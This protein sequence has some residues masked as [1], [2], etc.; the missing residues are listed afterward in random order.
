[1]SAPPRWSQ[2]VYA[3]AILAVVIAGIAYTNHV[4]RESE[5]KWCG[6]LIILTGGPPPVTDRGRAVA[7]AM[8][9]LRRDFGC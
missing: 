1:M 3:L 7:A 9:Q 8:A 6:I 4:Q 5:R 2:F